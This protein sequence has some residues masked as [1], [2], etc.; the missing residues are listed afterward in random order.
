MLAAE[1]LPTPA[2]ASDDMITVHLAS[3]RAFT[4]ALDARTNSAELWLRVN[5]NGVELLRPIP[6]DRVTS[7]DVAGRTLPGETLHGLVE[8]IRKTIPAQPVRAAMK[9]DIMLAGSPD[10]GRLQANRNAR[11]SEQSAETPRVASLAIEAAVGRWDENV[12]P[13]GLVV[14]VYPLDASGAI[15]PV[16]GT[17]T[18]DLKLEQRNI[19]F[20]H[21]PFR[22][23]GYWSE[24]VHPSDFGPRGAVYKLRFQS[25]HPEFEDQLR[26][27]GMVH[28]CLAVPGQGTFEASAYISFVRPFN[29]ARQHLWQVTGHRYFP[30][31]R[32]DDGR[33]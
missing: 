23:A 22:D 14:R 32:T 10:A 25:I 28:A 8:E 7:V 15:I 6:W 30:N 11:A 3:G 19:N 4:A 33:H 20:L 2:A 31:E 26:V 17:L 29:P 1:S 12:D 27:P 18:A 16:R 13:D 9:N 24:V 5:A 21:E